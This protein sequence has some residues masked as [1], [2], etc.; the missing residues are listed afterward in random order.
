MKEQIESFTGEYSFLSNFYYVSVTYDGVVYPSV[1]HAYQAAKTVDTTER[2]MVQ[3]Q[4]TAGF[5][6][7][8]GRRV[9]LRPDWEGIKVGIMRNLLR[10]K[11]T[12]GTTLA[13]KL[14]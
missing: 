11:F 3:R 13:G 2:R 8:A 14:Q 1:E 7:K 10:S 5:A 4:Q 12:P 9:T 6:K